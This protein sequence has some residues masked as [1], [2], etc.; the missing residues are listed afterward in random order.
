M[1]HRRA[2][3]R[4]VSVVLLNARRLTLATLVIMISGAAAAW[5]SAG[6]NAM[7]SAHGVAGPRSFWTIVVPDD[8][9]HNRFRN[10]N[11]RRNMTYSA[12]NSP[13]VLRGIQPISISISGKINIQAAHC[14]KKHRVCK[15][16]QKISSAS[17]T[18]GAVP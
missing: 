7:A 4:L 15:I 16:R 18:R 9:G 14:K 10:G 12:V 2:D 13:T 3:N 11:G 6:A 5:P 8:H 1:I 17:W